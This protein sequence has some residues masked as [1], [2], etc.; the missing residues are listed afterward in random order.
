MGAQLAHTRGDGGAIAAQDDAKSQRE[1]IAKP[2]TLAR[3][4]RTQGGATPD[5]AHQLR[6][7]PRVTRAQANSPK[8]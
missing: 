5:R 4:Y 8:P 6:A 2:E 1:D 3:R 7:R